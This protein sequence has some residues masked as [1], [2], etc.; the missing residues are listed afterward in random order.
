LEFTE[1]LKIGLT[2]TCGDATV[3]VPGGAFRAFSAQLH[4]WGFEAEFKFMVSLE[5]EP[6]PLFAHLSS[7]ALIKAS[8]LVTSCEPPADG[9]S[10]VETLPFRGIVTERRMEER[11]GDGLE[12]APVVSRLYT[13]KVRD[14]AQEFWRQHFP[15]DLLVGATLADLL[16]RHKVGGLQLAYDWKV[17]MEDRGLIC[18]PCG[19]PDGG[20]SFYDFVAWLCDRF[21]GTL[22]HDYPSGMF[23]LAGKRT[24][25]TSPSEILTDDVASLSL[26]LPTPPRR[27]ARV[28]NGH[29]VESSTLAVD[30]AAAVTGVWHE[31]LVRSPLPTEASGRAALEKRRLSPSADLAH[32]TFKRF[33]VL[34]MWPGRYAVADDGWSARARSSKKPWRVTEFRITARAAE[35]EVSDN[36][37]GEPTGTFTLSASADL[38][39]AANR[40]M[41]RIP[42]SPPRWPLHVEGRVVSV[43]GE[44]ADRT[45]LAVVDEVTSRSFQSIT[46]PLWNK[47][48]VVPFEPGT[49]PGNFFFPP[50]KNARVL[51]AL[52]WDGARVVRH[53]DWATGAQT[54]KDGQGNRLLFGKQSADGTYVEHAYTSNKPVLTIKRTQGNDVQTIVFSDGDVKFELKEELTAV[55]VTP[56]ADLSIEVEAAKGRINMEV[57]GGIQKVSKSFD[58]ALGG[59]TAAL[60]SATDELSTELT[61]AEDTLRGKVDGLRTELEDA[62]TGLGAALEAVAAAV[63]GAKSELIAAV[64][65]DTLSPK[66]GDVESLVEGLLGEAGSLFARLR[67]EVRGL[68]DAAEAPLGQVGARLGSGKSTLQSTVSSLTTRIRGAM[69]PQGGT[70]SSGPFAA[71]GALTGQVNQVQPLATSSLSGA[72]ST[73]AGAEK[74]LLAPIDALIAE[75]NRREGRLKAKLQEVPAALE[76]K[77]KALLQAQAQRAKAEGGAG[78]AAAADAARVRLEAQLAQGRAS[79]TALQTQLLAPYASARQAAERMKA[80]ALSPLEPLRASLTSV[81]TGLLQPV[82][83]LRTTLESQQKAA[84]TQVNALLS[85][86]LSNLAVFENTVIKPL[87]PLQSQVTALRTSLPDQVDEL[88][89]PILALID[90]AEQAVKTLDGLVRPPLETARDTLVKVRT[91]LLAQVKTA[92]DALDAIVTG[93]METVQS[94]LAQ[95]RSILDTAFEVLDGLL[96]TIAGFR[97]TILPPL[98]ALQEKFADLT[99]AVEEAIALLKS[100]LSTAQAALDAIPATGLLEP[101]VAPTRSAIQAAISS[102]LPPITQATTTAATQLNTLAGQLT[103]QIQALQTQLVGQIPTFTNT[104]V[105]QIDAVKPPITAQLEA[106]QAQLSALSGTLVTQVNTAKD[107]TLQSLQGAQSTLEGQVDAV[108]GQATPRVGDARTQ[109]GNAADSVATKM[110]Q[111]RTTLQAPVDRLLATADT[112]LDAA[113]TQAGGMRQQVDQV[114]NSA[115]SAV[116]SVVAPLE[117]QVQATLAPVRARLEGLQASIKA[118]VTPLVGAQKGSA[119]AVLDGLP[120]DEPQLAQVDAL[121]TQLLAAMDQAAK[122]PAAG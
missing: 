102:G 103:S 9:Y 45:W 53:L 95:V 107:G 32:L 106:F 120:S 76:A 19:H 60:E 115:E 79:T 85:P 24:K 111:A 74:D 36:A 4:P 67:A 87:E 25:D 52:E 109:L 78:G 118:Q 49:A 16:D 5:V 116:Q 3:E 122:D 77:Q 57:R 68:S 48:V 39:L 31:H 121:K 69:P 55:A 92:G 63:T 56:K 21:H 7:N 8:A 17:L 44:D 99:A 29:A 84:V 15:C 71:F 2:L 65:Q 26:E 75:I 113:D 47:V 100:L 30:N 80:G 83:A 93:G 6:D 37:L 35:E 86:L 41:P 59:T 51:V 50:Y 11:A 108:L 61:T 28:R 66:I 46:L 91:Q 38:E 18:V 82:T 98:E 96:A 110:E 112:Q 62:L 101:L 54:P 14:A 94:V 105:T 70:A 73:L 104:L 81:E 114:I 22:E 23:R 89:R 13:L 90:Q 12:G 58:A 117:T 42:Y 72:R 40:S 64:E 43:G 34:G 88:T 119:Q 33:P 1:R 20:T 97:E 10:E 27:A